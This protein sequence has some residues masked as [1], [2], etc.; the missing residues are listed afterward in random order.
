LPF[1]DRHNGAYALE[2]S[3]CALWCFLASPEDFEQ[4]LFTAVDAGHDADTVAAMACSVAGAYHGYARLPP[5]L[6]GDLEYH[7][8]L[9]ELAD[10]LYDLNRRLYGSA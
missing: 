7:E 9:V 10:G 1:D 3:P 8:R 6:L 5:R 2:S 4:I